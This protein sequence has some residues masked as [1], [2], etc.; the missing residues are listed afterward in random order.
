MALQ[1]TE[2]KM[3]CPFCGGTAFEAIKNRPNE[4][5]T[6]CGSLRR[7]RST[8]LLLSDYC[9]VKSTDRV[10]HFAPEKPISDKLVP[11][12]GSNYEAYDLSPEKYKFANAR[13]FDL[14][15]DL[16]SLKTGTYDIVVHNHVLEHV[17]CNYTTVL[18]GLDSLLKPGG[19]HVFSVPVLKGYSGSDLNPTLTSE[20]RNRRFGQHDHIRRFGK[21]DFDVELG[22]IL[23]ITR[24]Y[25]LSDYIP[26]DR[27]IS[28]NI[29]PSHWQA[30][31]T[32]TVF[33]VRKR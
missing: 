13:K 19:F 1:D 12:C 33:V 26:A 18:L 29:P 25:N 27:L 20:Q 22:A 24:E 4:R 30:Q 8:W 15:R 6:G 9:R 21:D 5:C 28:A 2:M 17:P 7:T 16:K 10:A 32:G 23:G 3:K 31:A 14:C 11:L